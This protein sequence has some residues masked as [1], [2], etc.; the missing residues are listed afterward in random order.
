MIQ[1]VFTVYDS[2]VGAYLRPFF[3]TTKGEALRAWTDTVND[4]E[5]AF[6]KHPEDYCLF[7]L[8]T[9][10]DQVG[11]F[12]NHNQPIS[13]GMALELINDQKN[14]YATPGQRESHKY[15]EVNI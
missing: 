15:S 8:G 5:T 3:M 14:N 6:N 2:K 4:K 9:F 10:D 11:Q 1:R 7:E 13:L 12:E